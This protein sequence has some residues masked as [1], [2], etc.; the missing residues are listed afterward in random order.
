ME[1]PSAA[2]QT[3]I[4]ISIGPV[5]DFIA[6]AR[7]TRDL[8]FGSYLLSELS[9][10]AA[11]QFRK[12]GELIMP[13][14]PESEHSGEPAD[15][16]PVANKII[17]MIRGGEP[18]AF[19]KD[20]HQAV[21][22]K[23]KIYTQLAQ[24]HLEAEG[25]I[26]SEMW[27]RQVKDFV[28]FH[29]AWSRL[30]DE[31]S[32]RETLD[33]VNQLLAGRKTL[34]DFR[35][36]EPSRM[37]GD[38]KSS[39]NPGRES[40]LLESRHLKYARFGISRTETLDAISLVKRLSSLIVAEI[41]P[42][43]GKQSFASVCDLAF[44]PFRNRM[45]ADPE[46]EAEAAK[47]YATLLDE[48]RPYLA[49]KSQITR[50]A[51][52]EEFDSRL[53]YP[54]QMKDFVNE[55]AVQEISG[56]LFTKEDK[57][58]LV[59]RLRRILIGGIGKQ[60][61]APSPYYAFLLCDGDR[62]G[63]RLK[64]V[65]DPELHRK[66]TERLSHFSAESRE[67]I[68]RNDG[69]F[70]YGGGDDCMALLPLHT[71]LQAVD[72]LRLRFAELMRD[73]EDSAAESHEP[74]TLSAGLVIAHMLEP[75]GQVRQLAQE[76]ERQ[77]KKHRNRLFVHVQKR[78][79]GDQ[80]KVSLPWEENPVKSLSDWGQ[81][82]REDVIP[83]QLAHD[84]RQLHRTYQR[85]AFP[86]L[87]A[88]DSGLELQD[89]KLRHKELLIME[90]DRLL[91]KKKL[92]NSRMSKQSSETISQRMAAIVRAGDEDALVRLNTLTEQIM[93]AMTLIKTEAGQDAAAN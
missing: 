87:A 75:L 39:L 4:V 17:G 26:N 60:K 74:I 77:A 28:E 73:E 83:V 64:K 72:E 24:K 27:K 16:L 7:R 33:R 54:H 21:L 61:L 5:Q 52:A 10:A 40:V 25:A 31:G 37:Y 2:V 68:K 12:E 91:R 18:E 88:E 85:I 42:S 92:D 22:D 34:R 65:A 53:F 41:Q 81:L 47:L 38:K 15:K 58:A 19:V 69:E 29:A 78:G 57:K 8:W 35:Q 79:G 80:L 89:Q 56:R 20:V 70:I 44:S 45:A 9:R 59:N 66:W 49:L 67:I 76:A 1:K 36:N 55:H 43:E 86:S 6:Q 30:P 90:V 63:D 48:C 14:L 84:L 23:W 93:L 51:K 82:Y 3:L 50:A 11:E 32:Y 13:V 62:I 71:C 46:L